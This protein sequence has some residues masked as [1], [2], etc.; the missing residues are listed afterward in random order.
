M[1]DVWESR[2]GSPGKG[3]L[4]GIPQLCA[5]PS[6]EDTDRGN[7]IC[8]GVLGEEGRQQEQMGNSS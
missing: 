8:R 4:R 2:V 6:W 1:G 7:R 5:A 3:E